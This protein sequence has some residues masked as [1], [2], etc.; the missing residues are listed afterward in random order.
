[1][2]TTD[3][4]IMADFEPQQTKHKTTFRFSAKDD[5]A[6]LKEVIAK[7]PYG[8]SHG[9]KNAESITP[10]KEVLMR[11]TALLLGYWRR[12][13][14]DSL[15]KSG[16]DEEYTEKEQLLTDL[17]EMIENEQK[18]AENESSKAAQAEID[19]ETLRDAALNGLCKQVEEKQGKKASLSKIIENQLVRDS[20]RRQ[21]KLEVM[22]QEIAIR[23]RELAVRQLEV[24]NFKETSQMML[25]AQKQQMQ[26]MKTVVER[27]LDNVK[28]K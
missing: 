15:R 1:M 14:L 16:C 13:E 27:V 28:E 8:A 7:F 6:L 2:N 11:R 10:S 4:G 24:T 18:E 17:I 25:E 26:L 5:V 22:Q 23:E 21:K 9:K 3:E 19:G 12:Q 20:E